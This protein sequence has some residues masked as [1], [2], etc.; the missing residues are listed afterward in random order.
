ME[1]KLIVD[2]RLA[3][4][5]STGAEGLKFGKKWGNFVNDD[6][7]LTQFNAS[8][9]EL[10]F[11]QRGGYTGLDARNVTLHG[12]GV[13]FVVHLA[14]VAGEDFLKIQNI[15]GGRTGTSGGFTDWRDVELTGTGGAGGRSGTPLTRRFQHPN[16]LPLTPTAFAHSGGD[17]V[18]RA[19]GGFFGSVR[20]LNIP[21]IPA[22]AP[23]IEVFDGQTVFVSFE[24]GVNAN[25]TGEAGFELRYVYDDW[26]HVDYVTPGVINDS[27][28]TGA[29]SNIGQT[30]SATSTSTAIST[31]TPVLPDN[32][33]ISILDCDLPAV[34]DVWPHSIF[35]ANAGG[36]P[37]SIEIQSAFFVD[38][39]P[40]RGFIAGLVHIVATVSGA[41]VPRFRVI[42]E[43]GERTALPDRHLWR[44]ASSTS[45]PPFFPLHTRLR[46][47]EVAR[48]PAES[49]TW[50]PQA[51]AGLTPAADAAVQSPIQ[52][53]TVKLD[54]APTAG[55]TVVET[56][57]RF[58][59]IVCSS[60]GC[61]HEDRRSFV[62]EDVVDVGMMI[63]GTT[64]RGGATLL[65]R[66]SDPDFRKVE[67]TM[68]LV[69]GIR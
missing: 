60:L 66:D 43:K 63:S 29:G 31:A 23:P 9:G 26:Y 62:L 57:Y 46:F 41:D 18:A 1:Q 32:S 21:D 17:L 47:S 49:H 42:L 40:R 20:N 22:V 67:L 15:V 51:N 30:S 58:R 13:F 33:A 19:T 44:S 25:R 5:A 36:L 27:N 37:P 69:Y 11:S 2:G 14:L 59:I 50:T 16:A 52:I 55:A 10:V 38:S 3:K 53:P 7:A 12:P 34:A 61:E 65:A 45:L 64:S 39:D 54:F 8:S 56:T 68:E 4:H 6:H 28:A 24:P 35:G 48:W